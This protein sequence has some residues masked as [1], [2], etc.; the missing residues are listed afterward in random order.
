MSR[1]YGTDGSDSSIGSQL[2]DFFYQKKALIELKKEQYFM[3][4]ASVIGMP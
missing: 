1:E 3:P 4:M 2:R